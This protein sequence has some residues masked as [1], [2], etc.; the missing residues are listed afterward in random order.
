MKSRNVVQSVKKII[1]HPV[2]DKINY[3]DLL[4]LMH[5]RHQTR[6]SIARTCGVTQQAYGRWIK[7]GLLMPGSV[8]LETARILGVPYER[9][10]EIFFCV[11]VRNSSIRYRKIGPMD[12]LEGD[13]N[14]NYIPSDRAEKVAVNNE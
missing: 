7:S 4:E 9:F 13:R 5:V 2:K 6:K 10:G 3:E 14:I 8:I 12:A 11:M 1:P